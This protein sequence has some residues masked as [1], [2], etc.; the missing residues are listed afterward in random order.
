MCSSDLP[1]TV[2]RHLEHFLDLGGEKTVAMGG[3]LDGCESLPRGMSG[4]QDVKLLE[5]ELQKRGISTGP[6]GRSVLQQLETG[7]RRLNRRN[8]LCGI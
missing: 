5:Q 6:A 3:D 8:K 4:V 2:L 1:E 7:R